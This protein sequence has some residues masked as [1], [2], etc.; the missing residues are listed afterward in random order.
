MLMLGRSFGMAV[1]KTVG[2][3]RL[4]LRVRRMGLVGV[5]T[6]MGLL[7]LGVVA[8][9]RCEGKEVTEDRGFN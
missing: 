9:L 7:L 3:G 1:E 4:V 2:M 6:V 5:R 8:V